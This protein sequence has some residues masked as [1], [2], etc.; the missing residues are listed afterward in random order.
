MKDIML[1][2]KKTGHGLD[3]SINPRR[4]REGREFLRKV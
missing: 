4:T 3:V 2:A 1:I